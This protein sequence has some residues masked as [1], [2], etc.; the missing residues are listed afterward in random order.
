MTA[1]GARP[2]SIRLAVAL[3][4]D[5]AV[6][7]FGKVSP[8]S[9]LGRLFNE[10]SEVHPYTQMWNVIGNFYESWGWGEKC[11]STLNAEIARM[12]EQ[13]FPDKSGIFVSPDSMKESA[14]RWRDYGWY[15]YEMK[16]ASKWR[17]VSKYG[18]SAGFVALAAFGIPMIGE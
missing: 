13:G 11:D 4:C 16:R 10:D 14:A 17:K 9:T 15:D 12:A 5:A 7:G 3:T 6:G 8:G 1:L 18:K 2:V